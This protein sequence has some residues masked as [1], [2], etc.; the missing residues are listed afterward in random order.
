MMGFRLESPISC[1]KC[2]VLNCADC[3]ANIDGCDRCME[4]FVLWDEAI[5]SDK[6]GILAID[7]KNLV[8]ETCDV[9]CLI[10]TGNRKVCITC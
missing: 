7:R 6:G 1:A 8:C 2:N 9:G 3:T 4:R 10:C 5:K